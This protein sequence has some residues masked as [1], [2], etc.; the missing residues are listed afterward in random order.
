M[1]PLIKTKMERILRYSAIREMAVGASQSRKRR[2][3]APESGGR[4]Q[5]SVEPPRVS[6]V[7]A[8]GVFTC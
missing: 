5:K 8:K 1:I 2:I 7:R 6:S 4:T 3:V